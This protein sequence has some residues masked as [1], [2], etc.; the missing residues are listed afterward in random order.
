MQITITAKNEQVQ[1]ML[2]QLSERM[3]NL[4]PAMKDIGE[5]VRASIGKNFAATGRPEKWPESQR[6]KKKG[7]QT[8]S[9]TGRLRRSFTVKASRDRVSV[10]TNVIYAAIHQFGG[11]IRQGAR[12]EL[13]TRNR[14]VRGEK[15]GQFK[16]G[17]KSGR[18][19]TF[20]GSEAGMPARPFLMVQD[21]D[22]PEINNAVNRYLAAR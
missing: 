21:E 19:F 6:V 5:I 7:G 9:R 14:Y 2:R 10:G 22:W 20:R 13:F 16:K 12:S 17:I 18:G 11:T 15:K 4:T 8:L 3:R 1:Q